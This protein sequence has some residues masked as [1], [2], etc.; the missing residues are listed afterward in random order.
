IPF[1]KN[2]AYKDYCREWGIS[3]SE[4]DVF[5]LLTTI[6][7]RGPSTF[8]FEPALECNFTPAE[9]KKFRTRLGLTQSEFENLFYI[10][11]MTLVRLENGKLQNNFYMNYLNLFSEVPEA[12]TWLVKKRGQLLHDTK[13]AWL[14]KMI[15]EDV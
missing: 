12:L 1:K 11:H 8:I 9:L 6:G 14:L 10:S 5:I 15:L 2:P 3:E 7:R 13:Q 4:D